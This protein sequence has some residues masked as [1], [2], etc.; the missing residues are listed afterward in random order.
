M[1]KRASSLCITN[2]VIAQL[3][4]AHIECEALT[5]I[6]GVKCFNQ[7]LYGHGLMLVTVQTVPYVNCL[8]MQIVSAAARM[9]RWAMIL[10]VYSYKI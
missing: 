3:N 5:I 1:V 8:A 7:Y 9:Q 2:L 6:F 10:N 4:Y